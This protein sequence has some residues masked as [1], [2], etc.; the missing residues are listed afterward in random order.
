MKTAKTVRTIDNR[1]EKF[2]LSASSP[3][4]QKVYRFYSVLGEFNYTDCDMELVEK[5][6]AST[7]PKTSRGISKARTILKRYGEY[8]NNSHLIEIVNSIN[9][10]ELWNKIKPNNIQKFISYK[11]YRDI[12]RDIDTWEEHNSLYYTTLFMA[13]YEGIYSSDI[14][15]LKNLRAK[16]IK[17]NKITLYPDNGESY[18]LNISTELSDRLIKLSEV[19]TWRQT[20]RYGHIQLKLE[21]VYPD[22]CFKVVKRKSNT[23]W[24]NEFYRNRLKKIA[25]DYVEYLLSPYDL[26]ISGIMHRIIE[27]L[28]VKNIT[29]QETFK[30]YN[31]D[32]VVRQVFTNEL[33]RCHYANTIAHFREMVESCLSVFDE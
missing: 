19:D 1:Y 7:N 23:N 21:S 22:N 15:V 8:T 2:I 5:A 32:K 18:T 17:E 6:I 31:K 24:E 11:Q 4:T 27:N 3:N 29:L 13:I 9:N 10:K 25:R 14:S 30:T 20:G 28:N 12:C 33:D 26:F 16:D